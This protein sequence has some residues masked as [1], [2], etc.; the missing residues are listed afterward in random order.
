MLSKRKDG[1][2]NLET[3]FYPI[4]LHDRIRISIIHSNK[5]QIKVKTSLPNLKAGR[6]LS[7]GLLS[8]GMRASKLDNE[9]NICFK[10]VK[11]FLEKYK[12]KEYYKFNITINKNI[13]IGAGLGGGSSNAA[14]VLTILSRYFKVYNKASL[15]RL[16]LELGSDVPFFLY[17][18]PAYATG[19]GEK[20]VPLPKFKVNYKILIVNP[21]I[22]VSTAWAYRQ[23][24]ILDF[25][26]QIKKNLNKIKTF[27]LS[28][29]N[30][31]VNDFEGVVFKKNPVIGKL[32]Q[33]M[34][35][36]GAVFA[37][38][39]GSGSTVYGFFKKLIKNTPIIPP[40]RGGYG[41]EC[42]S[43]K[44]QINTLKMRSFTTLSTTNLF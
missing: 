31:F 28:E 4:K 23:F 37:S 32:K 15:N 5:T 9:N 13:P 11:L 17:G 33:K 38:M 2:H 40:H 21:G 6:S 12:I 39:S 24:R 3:I 1:Y 22:N 18:K 14:S 20:L 30:K 7:K 43:N 8:E 29:K 42:F 19:R 16:A 25:G 10:A 35:D 36:D 41:E 26:F 34:Y 27:M 44:S